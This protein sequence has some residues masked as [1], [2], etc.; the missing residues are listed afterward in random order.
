MKIVPAAVAAVLLF[1]FGSMA[2]DQNDLREF[3]IGM[4]VSQLP[5]TGYG[6]FVCVG[7]PAKELSGWRGYAL[8]PIGQYGSRGMG[9]RYGNDD[10]DDSDKTQVGGQ[11]V[12]L[13]VLIGGDAHVAGLKIDTDQA[14]VS[15]RTPGKSPLWRGRLDLPDVTA[16]A[17]GAT[18]R[19][20]FRA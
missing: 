2:A 1:P 20:C 12:K 3:R 7:D 18:D 10:D 5:A 9:I 11:P 13:A 16:H 4:P 6:G 17:D 19:W 8:C 15:I 14:G